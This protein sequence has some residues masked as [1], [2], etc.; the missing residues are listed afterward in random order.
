MK[1]TGKSTLANAF[2]TI[3]LIA[4][5]AAGV[6]AGDA[7]ADG[8]Q[9]PSANGGCTAGQVCKGARFLAG[10][11]TAGAPSFSFISDTDTGIYRR[12][13]NELG[14]AVGAL[15]WGYFS[16]PGTLVGPSAAS[17]LEISASKAR[18][19]YSTTY[20]NADGTAASV[21][22]GSSSV[23]VASTEITLEP[24]SGYVTVRGSLRDTRPSKAVTLEDADGLAY[25]LD[26]TLRFN[27]TAIT[28]ATASATTPAIV[29]QE[30]NALNTGDH[31]MAVCHGALCTFDFTVTSGAAAQSHNGMIIGPSGASAISGSYRGTIVNPGSCAANTCTDT[32]IS[33]SSAAS[34]AEC[35]V[36]VPAVSLHAALSLTCYVSAAGT[37]QFRCCNHTGTG[38]TPAAGT[39][40][41]RVFNP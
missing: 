14:V 37:V 6:V 19:T 31:I 15:P 1:R 32:S 3:G 4:V 10:N 22:N 40:S 18:L 2:L 8:Q 21:V 23:S 33:V 27:N 36:G 20:F 5:V 26:S 35:A 17:A 9:T 13:V 30:V 28:A 7:L 12:G 34:G 29:L 38:Q 25:P 16:V 39:Y 11:G 24:S 41:V